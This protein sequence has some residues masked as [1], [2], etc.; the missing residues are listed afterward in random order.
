[1]Q[2]LKDKLANISKKLEQAHHKFFR[3]MKENEFLEAE[4]RH[5]QRDVEM[6]IKA[7]ACDL[8]APMY[9]LGR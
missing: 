2:E 9:A 7:E 6:L 3:L 1:M 5:V 4:L 8:D